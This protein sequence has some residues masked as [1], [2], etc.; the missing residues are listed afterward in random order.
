MT[1]FCAPSLVGWLD[2]RSA[3]QPSLPFPAMA[4]VW[5]TGHCQIALAMSIMIGN[6][7]IDHVE[8]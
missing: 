3:G 6:G 1:E 8:V 4:A 5:D 7:D 2:G